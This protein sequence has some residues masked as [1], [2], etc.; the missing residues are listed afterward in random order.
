MEMLLRRE[1]PM[2]HST[3]GKGVTGQ[4]NVY[5]ENLDP[6]T[7]EKNQPGLVCWLLYVWGARGTVRYFNLNRK[8]TGQ[9]DP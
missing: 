2:L 9:S 4:S 1:M 5:V 3:Y 7:Y 6:V 8:P